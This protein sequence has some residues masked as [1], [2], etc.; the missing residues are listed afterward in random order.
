MCLVKVSPDTGNVDFATSQTLS[1][2]YYEFLSVIMVL[3][4]LAEYTHGNTRRVTIVTNATSII[5]MTTAKSVIQMTIAKSVI[6]MT[7]VRSVVVN[8]I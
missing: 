3:I 4:E 6:T 1:K 5:Q 2:W 7:I 8:M